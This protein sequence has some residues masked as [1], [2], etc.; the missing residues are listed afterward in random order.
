MKYNYEYVCTNSEVKKVVKSF[1]DCDTLLLD[2]ETSSL[3]PHTGLPW[4]CTLSN[5]NLSNTF[6]ID[7]QRTNIKLLKKMLETK[8]LIGADIKFDLKWL[9]VNEIY[10]LK[11]YDVILVE[12]L[13]SIGIRVGG[14][15]L[16]SLVQRYTDETLNKEVRSSFITHVTQT[17]RIKSKKNPLP[18][19]T[20][21]QL[22]YAVEDVVHLYSIVK[23]QQ[24]R[25]KLAGIGKVVALEFKVIPSVVDMECTGIKVDK[26]M[27]LDLEKDAVRQAAVIKEETCEL[28][29]GPGV[30]QSLFPEVTDGKY[31]I[32][33]NSDKEVKL[34]FRNIGIHIDSTDVKVLNEISHPAAKKLIEYRKFQKRISTYGVDWINRVNSIT[35][36]IHST[37]NQAIPLSGRYSS[38]KPNVQ[39]IP[40]NE[41]RNT[42][43][44]EE[45]NILVFGDYSQ[46]ELRILAELSDDKAMID[47][48]NSGGDIHSQT[49]ALMLGIPLDTCGENTLNR[50]YGKTLN[51]AQIYGQSVEELARS[52]GIDISK[53]SKLQAEYFN[54]FKSIKKFLNSL[55]GLVFANGYAETMLGRKRWFN[56]LPKN[57]NEIPFADMQRIS[58]IARNHPIQGCSADMAKLAQ[59]YITDAIVNSKLRDSIHQINM[60]HDEILCEANKD[61][62][63]EATKILKDSMINA[64]KVFLKNVPVVVDVVV[65]N[66]W[67]K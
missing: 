3:D 40:N 17:D 14:N 31:I 45:D 56:A 27:W 58:R 2:L 44:C 32:N 60:A 36:R 10:P 65:S 53:A 63:K 64:G 4:L 61:I 23:Q 57:K 8:R 18:L 34:R 16:A 50:S 22:D 47:I 7:M 55:T 11:V 41:Y 12:R 1:K 26:S 20:E 62:E 43:I 39:Q 51:F 46:I 35:N 15:D 37:F 59:V 38:S 48:M 49:A 28:L 5:I 19:W 21:Q 67:V 25:I 24:S 6:V 29:L 13:L 52:L 9:F 30:P 54:Q 42:F 66:R 33:L